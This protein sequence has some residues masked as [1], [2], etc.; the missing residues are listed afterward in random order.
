[1]SPVAP[2]HNNDWSGIAC[3][4][5]TPLSLRLSARSCVFIERWFEEADDGWRGARGGGGAAVITP[6]LF[7]FQGTEEKYKNAVGKLSK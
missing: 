4:H 5:R 1:M 6:C 7:Y 2:D 3:K